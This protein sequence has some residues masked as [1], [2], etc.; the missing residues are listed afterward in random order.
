MTFP[1]IVPSPAQSD[2]DKLLKGFIPP[3]LESL[4]LECGESTDCG[5]CL[6]FPFVSNQERGGGGGVDTQKSC[7]A[8]AQTEEARS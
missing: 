7:V 4:I 3:N 5:I 8:S 6:F 2:C 1:S